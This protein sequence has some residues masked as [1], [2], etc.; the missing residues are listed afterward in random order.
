MRIF[1][2]LAVLMLTSCNNEPSIENKVKQAKVEDRIE[3]ATEGAVNFTRD[4]AIERGDGTMLTLRH[5]NGGFRRLTLE[6]DG[7]IDTSDGADTIT[8]QTLGDGRTEI[9]VG[10][11]RYRL[12]ATL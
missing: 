2:V 9:M 10:S 11:D 7:T 8:L 12:P 1:S 5:G 4:C 6:A 3:C